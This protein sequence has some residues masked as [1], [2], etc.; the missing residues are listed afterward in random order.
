MD[1]H[2]ISGPVYSPI[3][4]PSK[5]GR[6]VTGSLLVHIM[7]KYGNFVTLPPLEKWRLETLLGA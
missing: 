7:L 2:R 6:Q 3:F 5:G 4:P 1:L